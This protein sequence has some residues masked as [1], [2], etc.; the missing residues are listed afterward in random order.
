[1]RLL[2]TFCILSLIGFGAM[3]QCELP[4]GFANFG[5][6]SDGDL[7]VTFATDKLLYGPGETVQFYFI[8]ENVGPSTFFINWGIDPQDCFFI[9]PLSCTS[10]NQACYEAS[11][12]HHPGLV[13]F[14]SSGTT[15]DP[16]ECRIWARSWDT[17]QEPAE[18]GTYNVLGG[19]CEPTY[20]SNVVFF[21]VPTSGILLNLT[22]DGTVPVGEGTWGQIKALYR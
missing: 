18:A 12:F 7:N 6:V 2:V 5:V 3:A 8:V 22:I 1:M 9:M 15:L 21:H 20:D 11:V 14:Y 17:N 13:Y 16:G 4:A 10:V 19:M